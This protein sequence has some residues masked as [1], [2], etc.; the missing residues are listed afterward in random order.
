MRGALVLFLIAL[1]LVGCK[2]SQPPAADPFSNHPIVPPP[3][4]GT[5]PLPTTDPGY[6]PGVPAGQIQPTQPGFPVNSLGQPANGSAAG[7]WA[8]AGTAAQRPA[9]PNIIPVPAGMS[10]S[11]GVTNPAAT[12]PGVSATG[13]SGS[14]VTT[15][16]GAPPGMPGNGTASPANPNVA[17][18]AY[19]SNSS[20]GTAV[21]G[22]GA[23]TPNPSGAS[24]SVPA[25]GNPVLGASNPYIIPPPPTGIPGGS[26]NSSLGVPPTPSGVPGIPADNRYGVPT[27]ANNFRAAPASTTS[28][29]PGTPRPTPS[30]ASIPITRPVAALSNSTPQDY[31][32]PRPVDDTTQPIRSPLTSSPAATTFPAASNRLASSA[33]PGTVAAPA[34]QP[35]QMPIPPTAYGSPNAVPPYCSQIQTIVIEPNWQPCDGYADEAE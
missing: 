18:N 9:S 10:P 13:V 22:Y 32:N 14:A 25:M 2:S 15:T 23:V 28:P 31:R 12:G 11:N 6:S 1:G 29:I 34:V 30:Q 33:Q 35:R 4:T 20:L 7:A 3:G 27:G 26:P 21:P 16:A 17:A 5:C 19:P 8:P 24:A